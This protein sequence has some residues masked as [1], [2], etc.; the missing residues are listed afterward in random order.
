MTLQRELV[1]YHH[2]SRAYFPVGGQWTAFQG[3]QPTHV[4]VPLDDEEFSDALLD[5]IIGSS[6]LGPDI[7]RRAVMR[8]LRDG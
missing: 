4:A 3:A 7:Q 2:S 1:V 5:A 6:G 8:L